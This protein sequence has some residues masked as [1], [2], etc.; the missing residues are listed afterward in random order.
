MCKVQGCD[1]P[2]YCRGWCK[3]HYTRWSRHGDPEKKLIADSGACPA[4]IDEALATETDDCIM[5]PYSTDQDG[6]SHWVIYND[7]RR[8][9]HQHVCHAAH[10]PP[11]TPDLQ[12][13]H[14]CGK[15]GCINK[16]HLSWKTVQGNADDRIRHGTNL[17]GEENGFAKLTEDDVRAIRAATG[18]LTQIAERFGIAVSHTKRIR[19]RQSWAHLP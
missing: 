5:W 10:G 2:A 16:R 15:A 7:E 9:A 17:P 12:V 1:N 13:A 14:E 8:K 3:M 6:Y 19:D 4:F 18:T 11:E